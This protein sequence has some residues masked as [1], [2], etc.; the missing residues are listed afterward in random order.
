[1]DKLFTFAVAIAV[2]LGTTALLAS[3]RPGRQGNPTAEVRMATDGAYRDGLYVGRL[4]AQGNRPARPLIGRWSTEAD[5]ASFVA[6]YER[7]YSNA[8]V[9]GATDSASK[10][11]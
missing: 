10:P 1:M 4:A 5:R 7:G 8:I 9:S 11:E 2:S 3:N 6:G